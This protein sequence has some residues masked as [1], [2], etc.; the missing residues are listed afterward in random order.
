MKTQMT[1]LI[2]STVLLLPFMASATEL[3]VEIS[4]V[5]SDSGKVTVTLYTDAG[6][7]LKSGI[8]ETTSAAASAGKVIIT[9]AGLNPGTYAVAAHHDE[10]GDGEMAK[11]LFGVPKEG[12]GFSNNAPATF[13]PPDFRDAAFRL[14]AEGA[15]I[16]V[17]M[18]Y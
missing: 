3:K 9:L 14:D 7:F 1:A 2:V 6:T 10:D 8:G 13:G 5:Q 15:S 4:G 18:T 12:Y 16:A 17:R 11:N